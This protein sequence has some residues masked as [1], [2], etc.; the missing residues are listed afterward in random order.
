ML[1]VRAGIMRAIAGLVGLFG[2]F[3]AARADPFGISPFVV[4][5]GTLAGACIFAP[6]SRGRG[7]A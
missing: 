3:I 7:G 5:L 4:T 6:I 1:D 2:P